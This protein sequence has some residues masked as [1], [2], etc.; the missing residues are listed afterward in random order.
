M[1]ENAYKQ[2]KGLSDEQ[3][4]KERQMPSGTMPMFLVITEM[5]KRAAIRKQQQQPAPQGNVADQTTDAFRKEIE[6][7][8]RQQMAESGI[9]AIHSPTLTAASG[10]LVAFDQG[11]PVRHFAKGDPVE[12][13]TSTAGNFASRALEG[14]K[15][16]FDQSKY[17]KE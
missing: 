7:S 10:G 2:V 9:G 4:L 16:F 14:I 5:E 8:S 1:I 12:E 6:D 3:L 13:S 11:G 17:A 15:S